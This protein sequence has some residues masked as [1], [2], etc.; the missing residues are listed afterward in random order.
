MASQT[1]IANR[2][3]TKLG[4]ARITSITDSN[5]SA[6]VMAVLWDTVRRSEL[7]RSFWSFAITRAS[8]PMLSTAPAWG[9]AGAFQLPVDYL[10]LVQVNDT[11]LVPGADDYVTGNNSAYAI[12]SG[13]ILT[14]FSAPLKIRYVSDVTD[15]GLWDP[16]F[17]EVMATKLALEAVEQITDSN[18]KKQILAQEYKDV[19][20]IA[21]QAGAIERPP[22]SIPDDSWISRRL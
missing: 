11:F 18:Q 15:T 20:R 19:M 1:D 3:L 8:L 17:D 22:E 2:A 16:L 5:K 12:E 4:A 6:N 10:R 9:F 7:R 13:Q 21:V 14:D